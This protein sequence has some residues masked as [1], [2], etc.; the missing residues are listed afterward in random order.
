MG[1]RKRLFGRSGAPAH[2]N[3]SATQFGQELSQSPQEAP[4]VHLRIRPYRENDGMADAAALLQSVHDVRE[5]GL[6]GKN[7][8]DA[9]SFELWFHEGKIKFFMH[10]RTPEAADKF[11]RR[12]SSSYANSQVTEMTD[13][14]AFPRIRPRDFVSAAELSLK[15]SYY[16]P[17]RHFN[18]EGFERDPYSQVTSELLSTDETRIVLQVIF[19]PA[20]DTWTEG[21]AIRNKGSIDDVA[22]S[23]RQGKVKGWL[24]PRIRDASKK[25]RDAATLIENQRGHPGFHTNLRVLAI[26][27]DEYEAVSRARG[28][29][30]MFARYYNSKTEQGFDHHPVANSEIDALIQRMLAREWHDNQMILTVDELAS[31]AHIPNEDVNTPKIDWRFTKSGSELPADAHSGGD[32]DLVDGDDNQFL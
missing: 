7:V 27:P 23:L 21:G 19:R 22:E 1:L 4:G 5:K 17:I 11:R 32:L 29:A 30:Q 14:V 15:R 24:N 12:V 20:S 18:G 26:S 16:F 10:A 2:G 28:I 31:A 8:S 3:Y 9:H 6:R 13:G 25:D